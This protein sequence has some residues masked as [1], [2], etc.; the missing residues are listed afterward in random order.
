M[1]N[2]KLFVLGALLLGAQSLLAAAPSARTHPG[3]VYDTRAGRMLL[4]G[5][6]TRFD[7]GTKKSYELNDTWEWNTI[8]WLQRFPEHVPP[9][10][11][12]H[13]MVYDSNRLRAVIFG[14]KSD[15]TSQLNDTWVYDH[16]DWTRIDT[17]TAPPARYLVGGAYDPVRDRL[18]IFGGSVD[19]LDKNNVVQTTN[20]Y[21]TWEFDGVTWRQ[22]GSGNGPNI[23]RPVLVWDAA[24]KQILAVGYDNA[25]TPVN[26][27]YAYDPAAGAWNELKPAALP[28]CF[29]ES[30]MTF[31][32]HN[33]TV[34]LSGGVCTGSGFTDETWEWDGTNW[35][36]VTTPTTPDRVAGA[37]MAYDTEQGFALRYGGTLAFDQPQGTTWL[38]R[39][40]DWA[41]FTD[42]S[43][44]GPRSL[45]AFAT[46]PVTKA[47]YLYGG[48]NETDR[49]YD[50]WRYQNGQWQLLDLEGTPD[51]CV[52]PIATWDTDRS[53]LVMVCSDSATWELDGTTWKS[54]DVKTKPPTHNWSSLVY[55]PTLKKTVFYGG[56]NP[57]TQGYLNETWTW[58]GAAWTRVKKNPAP[59]RSLAMMWFD[60]TLKKTVV[61]GGVGR[62]TSLDR[63][64][65]YSDMW[66]FDGTGWTEIKNVTTPGQRYAAQVTVDP[67]NGHVVLFG[68]LRVDGTEAERN[69]VQV[70]ADDMWDWN[71]SAWTRLQPSRVPF[72]RESGGLAYDPS[73]DELVLF[74]GYAGYYYSDTW[75]H[76]QNGWKAEEEAALPRR[77]AGR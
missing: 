53:K 62:L 19:T 17:P 5:G 33:D 38:F 73:R 39:S 51:A 37:G 54:F 70:F 11:G 8:R 76:D 47:V 69:Q 27:M 56:W 72:A 36:K 61:Y 71:G 3:M 75:T 43:A 18:V 40:G 44:P 12:A 57:T 60:P 13:V 59:S 74:G 32:T 42:D 35:N 28:P 24:R 67:R 1:R 9:G 49:F 26:H 14:G 23:N 55:D 68:G 45:F 4:F 25:E 34:M 46:D 77:R 65:R 7:A 20:L 2:R 48:F 50:L 58:D 41:V 15:I 16:N 31:Q 22:I 29:N 21:D 30:M 64:I 6:T 52:L 63:V 10:R 66:S